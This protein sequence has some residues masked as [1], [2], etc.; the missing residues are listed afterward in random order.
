M[1]FRGRVIETN[2]EICS[3]GTE[4][5]PGDVFTTVAVREVWRGKLP[6]D[7]QDN[8]IIVYHSGASECE[9]VARRQLAAVV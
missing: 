2:P 9:Y 4:L 6:Q 1:I 3:D 8:L 5:C 7:V